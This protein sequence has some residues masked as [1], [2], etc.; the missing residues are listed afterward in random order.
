MNK[1]HRG[2]VLP[3]MI[4]GQYLDWDYLRE[5][6]LRKKQRASQGNPLEGEFAYEK[7]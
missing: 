5:N 2:K 7:V 6:I 4:D 3:I 1:N